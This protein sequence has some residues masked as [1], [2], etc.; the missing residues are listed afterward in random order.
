[1]FGG[2]KPLALFFY[3]QC[4]STCWSLPHSFFFLK[5]NETK[6]DRTYA[7]DLA[8]G[9]YSHEKMG[10]L[11][12]GNKL[13]LFFL[14]TIRREKHK[15]SGSWL[16]ALSSFFFF[17]PVIYMDIFF[18]SSLLL[19]LPLMNGHRL[20]STKLASRPCWLKFFFCY[21]RN[22]PGRV[23]GRATVHTIRGEVRESH[24]TALCPADPVCNES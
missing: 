7:K 4:R 11:S 22:P 12:D 18:S 17:F 15:R 8:D 3:T 13:K 5:K 16:F 24:L 2:P 14:L 21:H 19:L 20:H 9:W 1:M 10:K 6:K 23:I